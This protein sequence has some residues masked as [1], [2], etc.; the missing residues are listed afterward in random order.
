ME[1][2]SESGKTVPLKVD[3]VFR[4]KLAGLRHKFGRKIRELRRGVEA[5]DCLLRRNKQAARVHCTELRGIQISGLGNVTQH[6]ARDRTG[7]V[8]MGMV[9][10]GKCPYCQKHITGYHSSLTGDRLM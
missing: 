10:Y 1:L 5:L 8:V 7:T 9:L 2:L 3:I 6:A 4:E